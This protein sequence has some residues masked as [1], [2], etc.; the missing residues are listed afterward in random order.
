[1]TND[2]QNMQ[3]TP[4]AGRCSTVF[5]DL[6]CRG[7]RRFNHEVINWNSYDATQRLAVWQRLDAQLDQI[8]LPLLPKANVAQIE[9]FLQ[10]KRVRH[11]PQASKGRLCYNALKICEK[12]PSLVEES[13]LAVLAE[14]VKPIWKEFER[15]ILALAQASYDFAWLRADSIKLNVS[16]LYHEFDDEDL[17]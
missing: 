7:C 10:T 15:R 8:L 14:Q 2:S 5:G 3:L 9:Q 11:M 6:V 4:C 12:N 13:G 16:S 17:V 1:M